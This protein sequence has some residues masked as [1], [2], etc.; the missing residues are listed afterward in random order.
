[1]HQYLGKHLNSILDAPQDIHQ[2]LGN[3]LESKAT[4]LEH[5]TSCDNNI[6]L[7]WQQTNTDTR[8]AEL[9]HSENVTQTVLTVLAHPEGEYL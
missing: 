7:I 9:S 1:M 6:G 2:E 5:R 3:N 4:N 8:Q